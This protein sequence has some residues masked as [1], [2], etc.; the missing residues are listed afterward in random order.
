[1]AWAIS[2]SS[3]GSATPYFL[4]SFFIIQGPM[5]MKFMRLASGGRCPG[6]FM[7]ESI[8]CIQFSP[9]I[10]FSGRTS[11]KK[12]Q[13]VKKIETFMPEAAAVRRQDGG[14]PGL[15]QVTALADD[16]DL[17]GLDR[18]LHGRLGLDLGGRVVEV[19]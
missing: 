17:L 18:A 14:R 8:F 16:Q 10:R 19:R 7:N 15:L 12:P 2:S 6:R 3:P 9:V 4:A 11:G 5:P 13:K 1:M